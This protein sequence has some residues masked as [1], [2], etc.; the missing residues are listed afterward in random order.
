M[1]TQTGRDSDTTGPRSSVRPPRTSVRPARS[2][3][4]PSRATDGLRNGTARLAAPSAATRRN[5]WRGRGVQLASIAVVIGALHLLTSNNVRAWLRFDNLPTIPEVWSH[6]VAVTQTGVFYQ[7]VSASLRRVLL[8]FALAAVVGIVLGVVTARS[9]LLSNIF[10]PHVEGLRPI[11]AIALVPVAILLFP[12]NEAGIVFIT[13]FAAV[14][15]IIVSTRHAARAL[16][17]L[18]SDAV[19]TIGGSRRH[20]LWHVVLPG[21]LPGVFAG[22]SVGMGVAWI[23]VISAEMISGQFGVGYRT[24]QSY[25]VVDLPG[26]VVG[27]LTIGVLGW[28][29]AAVVERTGR[30]V[31]RWL[32][33]QTGTA[34]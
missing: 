34:A 5:D 18:W 7:D 20:V 10:R 23:C 25:T 28:L 24:W 16:S 22:L 15:P 32:P 12:T 14:F 31:N 11:P 26:V 33:E 21:S 19:R 1:S 17:P 29:T 4:R 27:M 9:R 13:F 2:N 8:G 6:A 3:G 30:W